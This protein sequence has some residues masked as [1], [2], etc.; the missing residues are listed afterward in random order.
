[1]EGRLAE[2]I[3]DKVQ[4]VE[5][6]KAKRPLA[7]LKDACAKLEHCRGFT[8]AI[9]TDAKGYSMG[10]IAEAKRK[11]PSAGEIKAGA[12]IAQIVANYE[13]SGAACV[14]VLTDQKHF[15]GSNQDLIDAKKACSVPIL[16][17]DFIVDP[18]QVYETRAIGAD[19]ILL[20][21]AA[22]RAD[23]LCELTSLAKELD[24][25]VLVEVHDDDEV[26]A[27]LASGAEL[28]GVNNRDLKTFETDLAVAERLVP[29]FADKGH[30]VVAESAIKDGAD[31][32][33]MMDAGAIAVLVGEAL[34]RADDTEALIS[35]L[36]C[37]DARFATDLP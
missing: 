9:L 29:A 25:E 17:K 21:V 11:S 10:V 30:R 13:R 6:A 22:L 37:K 12:D 15:G 35:D 34:M 26:D 3:R 8:G 2:I 27:A 20:I 7:E 1:M 18:W 5:A 24:L 36:G 16:R 31:A 14:S 32:Q 28:F 33:R 19:C 4:E 23:M